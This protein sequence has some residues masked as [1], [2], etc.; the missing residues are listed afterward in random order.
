MARQSGVARLVLTHLWPVVD[1]RRAV[2]EASA[3]YGRA[4]ELAEVHAG[5]QV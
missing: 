1:P 3:A 5:Y 2:E 4:V